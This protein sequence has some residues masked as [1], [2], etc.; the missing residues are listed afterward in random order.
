MARRILAPEEKNA[1]ELTVTSLRGTTAFLESIEGSLE[2][3][4]GLVAKNL[5]DLAAVCQH[6]LVEAFPELLVWLK[7]WER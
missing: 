2:S 6:R 1:L 5:R 4:D 3:D 7:K